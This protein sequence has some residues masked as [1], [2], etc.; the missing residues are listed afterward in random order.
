MSSVFSFVAVPFSDGICEILLI[1]VVSGAICLLLYVRVGDIGMS[2][3]CIESFG[4][5][6]RGICSDCVDEI[7][8]SSV[9]ISFCFW[10]VFGSVARL[11][12]K[13]RN[14]L[15]VS[16]VVLFDLRGQG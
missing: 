15:F 11:I 13:S 1:D 2:S 7:V 4:V 5:D 9:W 10:L 12:C 14:G 8:V 6:V 3:C 16:I